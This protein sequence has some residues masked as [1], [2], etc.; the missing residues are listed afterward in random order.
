MKKMVKIL[1]CVQG[2]IDDLSTVKYIFVMLPLPLRLKVSL[3][4]QSDPRKNRHQNMAY[5]KVKYWKSK[6]KDYNY[7]TNSLMW[8]YLVHIG[9]IYSNKNKTI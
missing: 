4:S 8:H 6:Y 9:E 1:F 2:R 5:H 7:R 3:D